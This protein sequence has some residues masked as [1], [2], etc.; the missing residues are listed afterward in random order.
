M[1][2]HDEILITHLDRKRGDQS[3]DAGSAKPEGGLVGDIWTI[4][5]R[6]PEIR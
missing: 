3:G 6:C 5:H 2:D 1:T 4:G